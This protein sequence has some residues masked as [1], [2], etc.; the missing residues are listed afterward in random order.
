MREIS[1]L[2]CYQEI[3]REKRMCGTY[4]CLVLKNEVDLKTKKREESGG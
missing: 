1:V 3:E 4:D 2:V